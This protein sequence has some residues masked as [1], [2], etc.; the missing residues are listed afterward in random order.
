MKFPLNKP[1]ELPQIIEEI[2]DA[3]NWILNGQETGIHIAEDG[4]LEVP[5]WWSFDPNVITDVIERHEPKA[6]A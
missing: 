2:D 4:S 1:V 6:T 3:C 5:D